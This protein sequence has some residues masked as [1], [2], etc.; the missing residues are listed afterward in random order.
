MFKVELGC[1]AIFNLVVYDKDMN[2]KCRS[3]VSPNLVLDAGLARMSTGLWAS[4]LNVGSG[5]SEPLPTQTGLDNFIASTTTVISNEPIYNTTVAP[6]YAGS[7]IRY[8]FSSGVAKGNLSEIGLGWSNTACW[9]RAR[10]LDSFGNPTTI[11]VTEDDYLDV[12]AEIRMYPTAPASGK[13]N[14]YNRDGTVKSEIDYTA[15]LYFNPA[16]DGLDLSK[17]YLGCYL[18]YK[19]SP[20][21]YDGNNINQDNITAVPEG[22]VLNNP[23]YNGGDGVTTYPSATSVK[24]TC[25]FNFNSGNG[26]TRSILLHLN[27]FGNRRDSVGIKFLLDKQIDKDSTQTMEYYFEASWGRYNAT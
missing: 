16:A 24:N 12:F 26:A 8:R 21:L 2:E 17:V 7:K 13:F 20:Y 14:L 6:Y 11:S 18:G 15:A 25:F 3:G 27:N 22:N 9:N 5:S 23:A 19:C 4:Q 10:I 1:K